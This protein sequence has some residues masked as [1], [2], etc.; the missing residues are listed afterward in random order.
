[1]QKRPSASRIHQFGAYQFDPTS[2]I[3]AN[4]RSEITLRPKV[5][6]LLLALVE[7]APSPVGKDELIAKVWPDTTVAEAGLPRLVNELRGALAD[8]PKAIETLPKRGYRFTLNVNSAQAASRRSTPLRRLAFAAVLILAAV[9]VA[10]G[11]RADVPS[12]FKRRPASAA[13]KEQAAALKGFRAGYRSWGLW[14]APGM[15]TALDEFRRVAL[16]APDLWFG[17][18][19]M[20]DAYM[21]KTLLSPGGD[22]TP[23]CWARQAAARGVQ[24]GAEVAFAHAVLGTA[25]LLAEWNWEQAELALERALS[26]N[27]LNYAAYQR[28]G[29]L[30][31]VE[32]RLSEARAD[33]TRSL[34]LQP[35]HADALV[36]LAYTHFCGGNYDEALS[37]LSTLKG[38]GGKQLQAWRVTAAAHAMQGRFPEAREALAKASGLHELDRLSAVAWI[39]AK[40][41]NTAAAAQLLTRLKAECRR[42]NAAWCGTPLAEAAL[43]RLDD[44]FAQ[45][46]AAVPR[47]R[48]EVLLLTVD[49]RLK[50]LHGDPRWQTF[51]ASVRSP[52]GGHVCKSR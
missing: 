36:M 44:A 31:L 3:L 20:A 35:E 37:A 5:A 47:R 6:E 19:G 16:T 50:P 15:D 40:A 32:G 17:Y 12:L 48:W 34:Q 10:I 23:L 45:L 46:Q 27:G 39:E 49:P 8:E 25:Y 1:M 29:L 24:V 52:R 33:F 51:M 30:R 11:S 13:E 43:G 22:L 9:A 7:T 42:R 18:T 4:H 26:I 21:G 14:L 28:R 2:G 41:G 38:G